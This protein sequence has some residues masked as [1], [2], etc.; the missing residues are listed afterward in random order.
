MWDKGNL[1]EWEM[2][3]DYFCV[4]GGRQFGIGVGIRGLCRRFVVC[5]VVESINEH[6]NKETETRNTDREY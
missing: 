2:L 1:F 3:T 4:I 5:V 6:W